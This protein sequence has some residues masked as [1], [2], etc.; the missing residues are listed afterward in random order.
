[1]SDEERQEAIKN[2]ETA[3]RNIRRMDRLFQAFGFVLMLLGLWVVVSGD[4]AGLLITLIGLL[5]LFITRNADRD[6]N[7]RLQQIEELKELHERTKEFERL[8][9]E[10]ISENKQ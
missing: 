3:A 1:M 2:L 9:N 6:Y 10:S 4:K 7:H 8:V 5:N